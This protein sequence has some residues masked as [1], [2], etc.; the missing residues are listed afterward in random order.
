[1]S[2]TLSTLLASSALV[3]VTA[4][5]TVADAR[6]KRDPTGPP[7]PA[8][9]TNLIC[10]SVDTTATASGTGVAIIRSKNIASV[11]RLATG[12]YCVDPSNIAAT[13]ALVPVV[14]ADERGAAGGSPGIAAVDST[15]FQGCPATAIEVH[16]FDFAGA[17]VDDVGFTLVA[18]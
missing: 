12:V 14:S 9:C 16:T 5:T 7:L 4:V 10:V 8:L 17:A 18:D 11:V 13:A 3:L 2:R 6:A 1:M 15:R